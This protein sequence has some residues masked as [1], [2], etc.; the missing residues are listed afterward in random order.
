MTA[1]NS[2]AASSWLADLSP[3]IAAAVSFAL[4][5][6]ASKVTFQDGMDPLSLS[7]FRSSFSLIFMVGWLWLQPPPRIERIEFEP[8]IVFTQSSHGSAMGQALPS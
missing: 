2:T 5:D 3:G 8:G 1:S 4:A 6:V 7:T